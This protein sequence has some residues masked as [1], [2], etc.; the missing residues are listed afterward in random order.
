MV[1]MNLLGDLEQSTC[2][3]NE[4]GS[5]EPG[6]EFESHTARTNAKLTCN[7]ADEFK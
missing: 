3:N 1:V 4:P 5:I 7:L 2:G 6:C